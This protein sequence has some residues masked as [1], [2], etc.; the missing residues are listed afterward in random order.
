MSRRRISSSKAILVL[1]SF[2]DVASLS[3][4]NTG[5]GGGARSSGGDREIYISV[6]N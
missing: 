2:L 3:T 4:R 5:G 6:G 1:V